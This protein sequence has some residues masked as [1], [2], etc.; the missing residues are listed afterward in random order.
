MNSGN[1][2][3]LSSRVVK[4]LLQRQYIENEENVWQRKSFAEHSFFV[5]LCQV[6]GWD[7]WN[8]APS[9]RLKV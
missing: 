9:L 8:P 3:L 2:R 7:S 4:L 6:L 1:I 5:V